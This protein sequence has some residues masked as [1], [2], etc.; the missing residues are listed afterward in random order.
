MLIK[1]RQQ[2]QSQ[3]C[4][5]HV[6]SLLKCGLFGFSR[7]DGLEAAKALTKQASPEEERGSITS[8]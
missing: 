6:K 5:S 4:K 3:L 7:D 1:R 2:M 8:T